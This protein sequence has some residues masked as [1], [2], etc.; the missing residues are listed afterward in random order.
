MENNENDSFFLK[1]VK[2]FNS[3]CEE[4]MLRP[5]LSIGCKILDKFFR[6]GFRS[7]Y[8]IELVGEGGSGKSNFCL[9]LSIIVK[10]KFIR[11]CSLKSMEA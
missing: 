2:S 10:Y 8:L 3:L 5:K 1:N 4:Q 6:G 7:G 11:I 9:Q